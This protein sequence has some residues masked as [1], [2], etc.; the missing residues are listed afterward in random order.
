MTRNEAAQGLRVRA[1]RMLLWGMLFCGFCLG[2]CAGLLLYWV[3]GDALSWDAW[4]AA[5]VCL[6]AVGMLVVA[7]RANRGSWTL[8]ST[9]KGIEGERVV[10]DVIE[11][12]LMRPNCEAV[13]SVAGT[14]DR[15][16]IDHLVV[17]PAGVW[18]V[19]TKYRW[20]PKKKYRAVMRRL[21]HNVTSL[22]NTLGSGT[23]VRGCLV[24]ATSRRRRRS[25]YT[26]DGETLSVL[27][28]RSLG[29]VLRAESDREGPNNE[30]VIRAVRKLAKR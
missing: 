16:E 9:R 1:R 25:R 5:I 19:E 4:P 28:A 24:L 17:T 11:S 22:R 7:W 21:A 26:A 14:R 8:E 23:A 30:W 3:L 18:V 27:S 10:G 20:V 29:E 13:H 6:A 15:G 12:A 2:L